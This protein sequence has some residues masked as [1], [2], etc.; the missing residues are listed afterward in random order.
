MERPLFS[1]PWGPINQSRSF[2]YD[3]WDYLN[4]TYLGIGAGLRKPLVPKTKKRSTILT[5]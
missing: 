1:M 3:E 4:R 2:R 5:K